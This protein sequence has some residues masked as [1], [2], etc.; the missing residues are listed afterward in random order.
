MFSHEKSKYAKYTY[1]MCDE[2]I[3]LKCFSLTTYIDM[4]ALMFID[5]V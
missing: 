4:S 1:W 3:K 5:K 2:I